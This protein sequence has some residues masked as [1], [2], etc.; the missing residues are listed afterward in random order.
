MIVMTDI[1]KKIIAQHRSSYEVAVD[2]T[3]GNGND[4]LFLAKVASTVYGL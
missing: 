2:M 3:V 1:A 4:T